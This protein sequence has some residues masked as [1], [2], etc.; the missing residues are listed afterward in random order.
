LWPVLAVVLGVAVLAAAWAAAEAPPKTTG[1]P[2]LAELLRKWD[3]VPLEKVQ[4]AAEAGDVQ[5]QHYLGYC[6]GE[7]WRVAMNGELARKWYGRAGDAGYLPSWNNL[8]FLY[9][10]GNALPKNL[11]QAV[12]YFR[13]AAE[14]G[15]PRA[16]ANLGFAY[17]DGLGVERDPVLAMKWFRR[18]AD[19]GLSTGMVAVGRLFRFG[20]GVGPDW[21]AAAGWFQKAADKGDALGQLNLGLLYESRGES[22]RALPLF[23]EAAKLGDTEAMISLYFVYRNGKGVA[24]DRGEA[25]K[26]VTQ[27]AEAGNA[28]GMCLLGSFYENPG[29]EKTPEGT[30]FPQSNMAEAVRWYRRSAALDWPGGQYHLGLC[31]LKGEGVDENPALGLDYIR[32]AADQAQLHALVEL[33]CLYTRGIGMPRSES[34]HPLRILERVITFKVDDNGGKIAQAYEALILRYEHGIGTER[35]VLTAVELQFRAAAAGV[36]EFTFAEPRQRPG[37]ITFGGGDR[38]AIATTVPDNKSRTPAVLD[39]LRLYLKA[40]RGTGPSSIQIGDA[41]RAGLNI[42]RS[43]T[44]AWLWYKLAVLQGAPRAASALSRCEKAMTPEETKRA[45]EQLPGFLRAIDE[46]ARHAPT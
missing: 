36:G 14:G 20:D 21:E 43:S 41:C 9:Q 2:S 25:L 16:Q 34:D 35:D 13:R 42:P 12:E 28:Y 39:M 3:P 8:G 45:K 29:W 7:G 32:K 26:W 18:A 19:N 46:I 22:S 38:S 24:A 10:R 33:A 5:A 27:S 40:A 11:A 31:Y 4:T 23:R 44:R 1:F 6:Y 15:L 37:W 17:Q 30:R